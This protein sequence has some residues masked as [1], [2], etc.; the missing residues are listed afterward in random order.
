LTAATGTV[1]V[2]N[3]DWSAWAFETGSPSGPPLAVYEFSPAEWTMGP[4]VRVTSGQSLSLQLGSSNRTGHGDRL[5][6]VDAVA[7]SAN[8]GQVSTALP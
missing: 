5:V 4:L 7:C 8:Q 2:P 6:M 3:S 1:L